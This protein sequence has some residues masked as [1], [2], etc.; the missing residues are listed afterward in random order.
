MYR[1]GEAKET[2][3]ESGRQEGCVGV[4]RK[5]DFSSDKGNT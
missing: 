4:R 2:N 3:E 5:Q 1:K